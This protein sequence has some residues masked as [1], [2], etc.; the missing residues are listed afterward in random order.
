MTDFYV[1]PSGGSY[2]AEDG[3]SYADAWD[4]FANISWGAGAGQVGPGDTLWLDSEATYTEEFA[5]GAS[6][7]SG[8]GNR[9]TVDGG[10]GLG[11][12]ATIDGETARRVVDISGRDYANIKNIK[13]VNHFNSG[14]RNAGGCTDVTISNCECDAN[15]NFGVYFTCN[16]PATINNV[17]VEDCLCDGHTGGDGSGVFIAHSNG[18]GVSNAIVRNCVCNDNKEAGINIY[19]RFGGSGFTVGSIDDVQVYGN[20]CARNEQVGINFSKKVT[21]FDCYDNIVTDSGAV[22]AASGIHCG[23]NADGAPS[24]GRIYGNEVSG[25][26]LS[27]TDGAGILVDDLSDDIEIYRNYCHDNEEVGIKLH[28]VSDVDVY[29]NL[30]IDNGDAGISTPGATTYTITS[31]TL[32]G[33][34]N[35]GVYI[36][37]STASALIRNNIITGSTIAIEKE[38]GASGENYSYNCIPDGS[39]VGSP[40]DGGNNIADDPQLDEQYKPNNSVLFGAAVKSWGTAARLVGYDGEPFPDVNIDMGAYQGTSS[41]THPL[42]A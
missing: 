39:I 42:N 21:N 24:D 35:R 20:S 18:G 37:S 36:R 7:T 9:I 38:A 29:A 34:T 5:L 40:T 11:T 14:I 2:G 31:N 16:D 19:S 15:V 32:S 6:G 26:I 30:S 1:R 33:N 17:I 10:Y 25:T 28:A 22:S 12:R 8:S 13:S 27:G 41:L 23:G 4:G 3:T